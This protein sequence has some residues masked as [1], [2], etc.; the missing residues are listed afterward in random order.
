[1]GRVCQRIE[2][3]KPDVHRPQV[4]Q[5]GERIRVGSERNAPILARAVEV[6]PRRLN[7]RVSRH[8][9]PVTVVTDGACAA[10]E[11]VGGRVRRRDDVD[12]PTVARDVPVEAP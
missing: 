6:E 3:P 9:V 4:P 7:G 2:A 11:V 10:G 12:R 1:M 5:R 8:R